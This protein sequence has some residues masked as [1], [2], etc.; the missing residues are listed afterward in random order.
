MRRFIG[1][2]VAVLAVTLSARAAIVAGPER[3]VAKPSLGLPY[4][5]HT[6]EAVAS[7]GSNFL[8]AWANATGTAYTLYL[9]VVGPDGTPLTDANDGIR[10]N[11][12]RNVSIVW[13]GDAYLVAFNDD[14]GVAQV[15]RVTR[16]GR[17]DGTP[18]TVP[19]AF[20]YLGHDA[21]AWDGHRALLTYHDPERQ[22][23]VLLDDHGRIVRSDLPVPTANPS[24]IVVSAAG[25]RFVVLWSQSGFFAGAP[26]AS[27]FAVTVD[28]EGNVAPSP[29]VIAANV[30][31]FIANL[32]AAPA[33]ERLAVAFITSRGILQR[34][35]VTPT[36]LAVETL[37]PIAVTGESGAKLV[38]SGSD[39]L[40]YWPLYRDGSLLLETMNFATGALREPRIGS[41]VAFDV[42][43]ASSAESLLAVWIDRRVTINV[44]DSAQLL[45][46]ALLDTG[47]A[48][49]KAAS[50]QVTLS[51]VS[52]STPSIASAGAVSLVAWIEQKETVRG[53]LMARR[54]DIRGIAID[55]TPILIEKDVPANVIPVAGFTGQLWIVAYS[56]GD[57]SHVSYRR[58][59]TNG[60]LLDSTA[61]DL[62]VIGPTFAANAKT[63]VFAGFTSNGI[64]AVR[65]TPAGEK[66]DASPLLITTRAGYLYS[67]AAAEDEFL[68]V[69][70]EGSNWW[71]F[72]SPNL[73]DIYGARLDGS[74]APMDAA[75]IAIAATKIDEGN[76]VVASNGTDFMVAYID[77]P[78]G[79]GPGNLHVKRVLHEGAVAGDKL[80]ASGVDLVSLAASSGRY[81]LV[82][83]NVVIGNTRDVEMRAATVEAN[84]EVL[85]APVVLES[86]ELVVRMA[87]VP[88]G[89]LLGYAKTVGEGSTRA[90]VRPL[91]AAASRNRSVR[92]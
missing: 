80:L 51:P 45:N 22:K 18:A 86:A 23:F 85:D 62:G 53:D 3:E 64:A 8:V 26:N 58:V 88:G 21:L 87:P 84:G 81:F 78:Q 2:A 32:S 15:A 61:N 63:S 14:R 19:A 72:P 55:A 60:T 76:A 5:S 20:A 10:I 52:Q 12:G 90:V 29:A 46:A 7:D 66:I 13:T 27:L 17:F 44:N 57:A 47:G 39:V 79:F 71:Q 30:S 41:A 28:D 68:V 59:A 43:L 31:T 42:R 36:T 24:S 54:V 50:A 40:A 25:G 48:S 69:W 65:F 89:V 35:Y 1:V 49:V 82:Y 37:V 67:L 74:G 9:S 6:L 34:A 77:L 70:G 38:R 33:D 75:P 56:S 91:T 16:E 73:R 92:H 11:A 4:G 83:D